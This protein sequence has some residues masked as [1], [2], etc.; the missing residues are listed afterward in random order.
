MLKTFVLRASAGFL[1]FFC[2]RERSRV[3][4]RPKENNSAGREAF[5]QALA[6]GPC[7]LHGQLHSTAQGA[8][9]RG[10]DAACGEKTGRRAPSSRKSCSPWHP[11]FCFQI[12][13]HP[14]RPRAR[15]AGQRGRGR[16]RRKGQ[17]EEEKSEKMIDSYPSAAMRTRLAQI[18]WQKQ[19]STELLS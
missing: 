19:D 4:S 2:R 9:W 12:A 16:P 18:S 17:E 10:R 11:K 3:V 14:Q 6:P 7:Q 13:S 1:L 8:S 15:S 5:S